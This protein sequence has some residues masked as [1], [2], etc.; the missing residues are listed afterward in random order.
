MTGV[1]KPGVEV[2]QPNGF[3]EQVRTPQALAHIQIIDAY[4]FEV[5]FYLLTQTGPMVNGLYSILNGQQPYATW[6][7]QNPDGASA[8]NRWKIT[9]TR[10]SSSRSW[11]Y[12]YAV[13]TATWTLTYQEADGTGIR[14]D[15]FKT[16]YVVAGG[17][18]NRVDTSI[19]R[20]PGGPD[21]YKKVSVY[22]IFN[23]GVGLIEERVGPDASPEITTY[24]YY[25]GSVLNGGRVPLQQVVRPHGGWERYEYD[26]SGR[27]TK[28]VAQ[29]GNNATNAAENVSRVTTYDYTPILPDEGQ[30]PAKVDVARKI[31]ESLNGH[32]I[33]WRYKIF[34]ADSLGWEHDIICQSAGA[35]WNDPANLTTSTYRPAVL[36]SFVQQPDGTRTYFDYAETPSERTATV[37]ATDPAGLNG[38]RTITLRN[39]SNGFLKSR[40][41]YDFVNGA[42]GAVLASEVYTDPDEFGRPTKITHLD[43]TFTTTQYACCGVDIVTDRD[44]VVTQY[45]YDGIK[46][47]T[48]ATR[49]G[50]T[51]TSVLDPMGRIVVAKRKGTDNSEMVLGQ[52]LYDSAGHV[53]KTTNALNGE[54]TYSESLDGSGQ[55]VKTT[56]Y[57]NGGTRIETYFKD[58][59]LA[60]VEGT[61]AFPMRYEYGVEQDAGL[62]RAYTKEI[63]LTTAG[64][65]TTE[66]TKTYTDAAGRSYKTIY[67]A[68][69]GTPSQQSFYNN[70]GQLW[71]QVEPDGVVTLFGYNLKGEQA[72][73]CIDSN[74]NDVIDFTGQD[75]VTQSTNDVLASHGTTVRRAR[76]FVWQTDNANTATLLQTRETETGGL[77]TWVTTPAGESSTVTSIPNAGNSWTR[78]VTQFTPEGASVVSV[79]QSG[80]LQ[81][82]TRKDSL[83]AQLAVTTYLYDTHGRQWKSIDARNGATVFTYNNADRIATVTSPPPG[84]GEGP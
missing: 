28:T 43:G 40:T 36:V 79:Y 51:A 15:E 9:E 31:I 68:S 84:N 64:A 5:R 30:L 41:V 74:R 73:S 22:R 71:K 24:H 37:T 70:L 33:S 49:L 76:S 61:A 65:D 16:E 32:E 54:T 1:I 17:V 19:V 21:A 80:R 42:Q 78:T 57:P 72:Y 8:N 12:E 39:T 20:K 77:R 83:A 56:T 62:W 47:R 81:S 52:S 11:L 29:V 44:G 82:V 55:T 10:S 69:S 34:D 63:K 38:T 6:I 59:S 4:K 23:W 35:A 25:T 45:V 48:G 26:G 58:G 66:W 2:L 13:A 14:Q 46:R 3:I 7:I 75:R 53:L 27:L 50:I 18:T 67:S 60:R